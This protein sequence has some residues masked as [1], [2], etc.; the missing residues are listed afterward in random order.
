MPIDPKALMAI[1]SMD[2]RVRT[3]IEGLHL[4]RHRSRQHGFSV[5]FSEYRNYTPGDDLKHLDWRL[6]A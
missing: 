1:R 5:E 3:L 2:L 4:G 6:M